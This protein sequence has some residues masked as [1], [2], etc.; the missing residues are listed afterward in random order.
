M[1][2]RD[3][4]FP[5]APAALC[6]LRAGSGA[7]AQ[8]L[9]DL[10]E[11]PP[12]APLVV[13]SDSNVAPLH[14]EPLVRDLTE[15]GLSVHLLTFPA[16]E[17]HKA[18]STKE[19]LE[20]GLYALDA[21]RHVALVAIGGG[22]TGD[23]AGF[24]ASTWHRGVPVVQVPT[25]LLAMVDAALGGKTAVNLPGG[26]NLVGTFHQPWGL[27]ADPDLLAT[28]PDETYVQGFAE[29]VKSAAIADAELFDWLVGAADALTRRDP[30]ALERAVRACLE[31]K[32]E[33]VLDDEREA[34]RRA[35]L[36]FGHTVAHALE[37]V[38]DYGLSHGEAV[39][40]GMCVEARLA[41]A[42]GGLPAEDARRIEGLVGAFGLPTR[43]PPALDREAVVEST[44]RDKKVKDRAV[45]YALPV[46]IGSM[47]EGPEVTIAIENGALR[48][49][50]DAPDATKL[51]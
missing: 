51:S 39:A 26:K 37:A 28:L 15:R 45:R 48:A 33:V 20:D 38:A 49:A 17:A 27:Y 30:A 41:V 12:G 23:L 4:S 7:R 3:I 47:P 31:I 5:P 22:V 18:R 43:V 29:I 50:L 35:S 10:S 16:G 40:I 19:R 13:I 6:R 9:D 21:D 11:N 8:L 14:A 36:N 2:T 1:H 34:G 24:V 25:S 44:R 32:A 46:A 42:A